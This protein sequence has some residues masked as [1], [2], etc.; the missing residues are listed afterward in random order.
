MASPQLENG[1]IPIASEIAE[2]LMKTNLS[3][4]QYR[5][6]WCIWRKTYGY[7]KNE[8]WISNSQ[9]VELTGLKKQHVSRTK[10]ELV[11]RKMVTS[12]GNKVR[13]NKN[14]TQWREL[15]KKVTKKKVTN[16]GSRVT[17]RS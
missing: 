10:N 12:T 7:K 3:S 1:Y 13:F 8:D 11:E 9:L 17:L 14:Y 16:S 2:A 5:L 15:P 4:Y 6:L